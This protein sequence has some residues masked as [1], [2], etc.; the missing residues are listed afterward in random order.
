MTIK[1]ALA[2]LVPVAVVAA[3]AP[4]PATAAPEQS[5]SF[6]PATAANLTT[7][8]HCVTGALSAGDNGP[9]AVP[10]VFQVF[11]ALSF[12]S[13]TTGTGVTDADGVATF[14]Y[15]GP[16]SS[17]H[18]VISGFADL[19]GNGSR[20]SGDPGTLE[21]AEKFWV[22]GAIDYSPVTAV[23]LSTTEHCVDGTLY[24]FN[25]PFGFPH[26][27]VPVGGYD[28]VFQVFSDPGFSLITEG[29]AT[30]DAT[31]TATFCYDGPEGAA[32]EMIS[33]FGDL[34]GN[35]ARDS[36]EPG[37][38]QSAEKFW[39]EGAVD[40][41]PVT[42]GNLAATEHCVDG[43]LHPHGNPFGF[44]DSDVPVGGYN[45]VF[46]ITDTLGSI[47]ETGAATTNANG[48]ATFCYDGPQSSRHDI[49]SGFGD[50]NGNGDLDE[51]EPGTLQAGEKFWVEGSLDLTPE[52]ATNEV[53]TEHCLTG[54]LSASVPD[55]PDVPVGGYDTIY[56]VTSEG[57]PVTGGTR[58]TASD[59]T[60]TFCYTGPSTPRS[61]EIGAFMD[62]DGDGV[63]DNGEPSDTAS[64][65]WRVFVPPELS[66]TPATA[67]NLVT[68][69]H[70]VTATFIDPDS[71]IDDIAIVFHIADANG[72]SLVETGTATTDADGVATFCYQGPQFS[73]HDI[74]S[75]F[76]DLNGDGGLDPGEPETNQSAEKFWLEA[77]IDFAPATAANLTSTEHCVDATLYPFNNPAGFPDG[78]PLGGYDIVFQIHDANGG[79]MVETGTATTDADG[80]A[81]FCYQ[82]PAFSRHDLI[83]GVGDLNGDG[84]HDPGEPGT[85]QSA[86]KFWL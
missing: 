79:S 52:N 16:E 82:G 65:T 78:A 63:H 35:G 1:K 9:A 14:C 85:N 46:Q 83:A 81:T 66:L 36:G 84:H 69:E 22:E 42:A 40:F 12:S 54:T 28:I 74:I 59:G 13:F 4:T 67:T 73:R 80:I 76:G 25:N 6:S 47:L 20:D 75:G 18:H 57:N 8:E 27:D 39:V 43:T 60:T 86:E 30:T 32:H 71:P 17:D 3:L 15:T 24:P 38:S 7:T 26:G 61:D 50:L 5:V 29:T 33:G 77:A 34:N 2:V 70:C 49:I 19:N 51:G 44:P 68:T 58:T 62:V 48:V 21:S 56:S 72:G 55:G 37:T 41:A 64:K 53:G 31:G 45:I 11:Q 10:I 23:N